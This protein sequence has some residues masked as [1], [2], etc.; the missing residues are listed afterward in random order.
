M[1]EVNDDP[2]SRFCTLKKRFRQHYE[3]LQV[4]NEFDGETVQQMINAL[5]THGDYEIEIAQVMEGNANGS[6]FDNPGILTKVL[7]I[8][9]PNSRSKKPSTRTPNE[10]QLDQKDDRT[11]LTEI[12]AII[13]KEPAYEEIVGEIVQE[14]INGLSTKLKRLEKELLQLVEKGVARIIKQEIDERIKAEKRDADLEAN[15]RLRSLIR[16][17]LDAEADHPTNRYVFTYVLNVPELISIRLHTKGPGHH[18]WHCLGRKP[19]S[20]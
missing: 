17:A 13:T 8:F 14:A 9:M 7:S 5:G 3:L 20:K 1:R 15:T 19:L 4:E 16:Q 12:C 18:S 10:Y 2:K 6:P 11:F